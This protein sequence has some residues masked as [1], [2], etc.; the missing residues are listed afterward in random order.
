MPESHDDATTSPA[1]P[2][3]GHYDPLIGSTITMSHESLKPFDSIPKLKDKS[4]FT[5]WHTK[6]TLALAISNTTRFIKPRPDASSA[7]IEQWDERDAQVAAALLNTC[8]QATLDAHI[9]FLLKPPTAGEGIT[10]A[11]YDTLVKTYGNSGNQYSF[12]LGRKFIASQ[13][14]SDD[15]Q[16][17]VNSV[18]AMYQELDHLKFD[19][20]SLCINV[21]LNGL[22]ERFEPFIDQV[23]ASTEAPTIE[24]L[25]VAIANIDAGHTTRSTQQAL[26]ARTKNFRRPRGPSKE[27]PCAR[28]GS[29]TH[30]ASD[31]P[32]PP[33]P[34]RGARQQAA[35]TTQSKSGGSAKGLQHA[36]FAS[37]ILS[38]Y[39]SDPEEHVLMAQ[40][41]DLLD[42]T[43]EPA[44]INARPARPESPA[45]LPLA[46][47]STA[48][49]ALLASANNDWIFDSGASSHMTGNI[50]LLKDSRPV[51]MGMSVSVASG[52]SLPVHSSGT[53]TLRNLDGGLVRLTDV[54]YVPGLTYN[55][56]SVH[57][58]TRSGCSVLFEGQHGRMMKGA[59]TLLD[60]ALIRSAWWLQAETVR[61]AVE[62]LGELDSI[63]HA[64]PVVLDS[65]HLPPGTRASTTRAT[66]DVWHRRLAHLN[67][68][69]M[70]Q[71]LG[72]MST[73]GSVAHQAGS[74]SQAQCDSTICDGCAMG[75]IVRPP[76]PPS[77]SRAEATLALV[78]SDLCKMGTRSVGGAEYM[79]VLIDDYSRYTWVFPL[80]RKSDVL[81][82]FK[83][84]L[85]AVERRFERKLKVFR[86]D[87]GGEFVA[88]DPYLRGLGIE[89]QTSVAYSAPQNGDAER[90][91]RSIIERV[92]AI[93]HS[94]RLPLALWAEVTQAVVYIKNR[95]P[96][97]VLKTTPFEALYGVKP[98]IMNLRVIGCAAWVLIPKHKRVRKLADRA[99]LCCFLGYSSTQKGWRFWDPVTHRVITSRDA[100]FDEGIPAAQLGRTAVSI[101]DLEAS[102]LRWSSTTVRSSDDDS[103]T[104]PSPQGTAAG[105]CDSTPGP[106]Q[107]AE[108]VGDTPAAAECGSTSVGAATD[109]TELQVSP[110]ESSPPP[111]IGC[112]PETPDTNTATSPTESMPAATQSRR[113]HKHWYWVPVMDTTNPTAP[114]APDDN[115]PRTRSGR[116]SRPA[117][118]HAGHVAQ[119]L[120]DYEQER[121]DFLGRPAD[122]AFHPSHPALVEHLTGLSPLA[123]AASHVST[124]EPQSWKA[125]MASPEAAQ[126]RAAAAD[127]MR[128]L[129]QAGVFTVVAR[130]E[131]R[132]RIVTSKWVFKLKHDSA[133]NIERFKARVVARGFL[134]ISGIDYDETFA[135]VV[136]FQSIRVI[137]AL[138]A[139][140]DLELHQMDVKTAFLYGS[141]EEEVYMLIQHIALSGENPNRIS[142]TYALLLVSFRFITRRRTPNL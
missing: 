50:A 63:A 24:S 39:T 93:M 46:P 75:K 45:P 132:G 94:E 96:T 107:C 121:D 33:P 82:V 64:L 97:R 134:Q 36:A 137:L 60:V 98:N 100:I 28:C 89:H 14:D 99:T 53:V 135:P 35:S 130:S 2:T 142:V 5:S 138:T 51:S 120:A 67:S 40:L 140:H 8:D 84:W 92:I 65:D 86:S 62:S 30:W 111:A 27:S 128:S 73:G 119:S 103:I 32:Q 122:P 59:T 101:R 90:A 22:P 69:A 113:E 21:L 4:S 61:P 123:L 131:I 43:D 95:S 106:N 124:L 78:H 16:A 26:A 118:Q 105:S 15:V 52:D 44:S 20:K 13:C 83:E 38:V 31:C 6:V 58:V 7:Q 41:S 70:R 25:K 12:A 76:F 47:S 49:K 91:N 108:A 42:S 74:V 55:L 126:W 10:K 88:L 57:K 77:D 87:N 117:Q 3:S 17:W 125:A 104:L 81:D 11:I 136:K 114:D 139:I 18:I 19:L 9:H 85:V 127:E 80:A 110:N 133:G 72:G 79:M 56:C 71:L 115:L 66:W 37:S 54:L 102:L 1:P 129:E 116:V 68:A 141:L 109:S 23:W 34:G 29:S 48:E 112:V